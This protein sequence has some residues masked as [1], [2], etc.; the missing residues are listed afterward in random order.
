MARFW[1]RVTTND[2]LGSRFGHPHEQVR[3][4]SDDTRGG[5]TAQGREDDG[6]RDEAR[7]IGRESLVNFIGQ[8]VGARRA[9]KR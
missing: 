1:R 5:P 6:L 9:R 2:G 7:E 8:P 4:V 3:L